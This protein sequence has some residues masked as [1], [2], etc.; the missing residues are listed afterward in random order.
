MVSVFGYL[1][2]DYEFTFT[3]EFYVVSVLA[4]H[5]EELPL[6]FLVRKVWWR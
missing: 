6:A 4:F 1:E 2:F 3:S 5:V